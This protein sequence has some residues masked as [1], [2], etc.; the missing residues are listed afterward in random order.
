MET[1]NPNRDRTR[2]IWLVLAGI[3]SVQIGSAI[4]KGSFDD[5]S[6]TGLTWLRLVASALIMVALARPRLRGHSRPDWTLAMMFGATLA[7]MNWAFYQ[8]ISLIPIGVAVTIEFIGPLS[9]AV[10]GSRRPRD[11]IWVVLAAVGVSLLGLSPSDLNWAGVGFALL[12]A[13]SWAAYILVTVRTGQRWPGLDGLAVA[14]VVAA[15]LLTPF[16]LQTGTDVLLDPHILAVG[17]L[18]GLLSSAVP[19]GL[20]ITALRTLPPGQFGI[21]MSLEPAAAA[22]AAALILGELLTPI[23]FLAMACVVIASIGSTR[24]NA[25]V[26][27]IGT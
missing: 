1:Q 15:L 3:G 24:S 8:A 23:Q 17:A 19:Y 18:I 2:A 6:P 7:F 10:L 11:L 9:V 13:A 21:L 12:A 27:P 25:P 26:A 14:S 20:E 22:L 5:I 16:A 4:G